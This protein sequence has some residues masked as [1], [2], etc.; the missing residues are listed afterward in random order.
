MLKDRSKLRVDRER[1]YPES[2]E[3]HRA[4]NTSIAVLPFNDGVQYNPPPR[5]RTEKQWFYPLEPIPG[6]M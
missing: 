1:D 5:V 6:S 2:I 4:I 3:E